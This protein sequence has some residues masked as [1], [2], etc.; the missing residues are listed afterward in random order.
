MSKGNNHQGRQNSISI[1]SKCEKKAVIELQHGLYCG[2]HFISYFENKVFRTIQKFKL[3][4]RNDKICVATSGGKDSL[5][6]LYLV[7]KYL[8]RQNIN[9]ASITALAIDEGIADYRDKT[10]LDLKKFCDD[11]DVELTIANFKDKEHLGAT[12]DI[13][14]PKINKVTGKKPCNVCGVWR[15]YLLNKYAKKLNATKLVT[16]HNLD[17]EAQAIMMNICKANTKLAAKLGPMSGIS[18]QAGFVRRIKPLYL[19]SEK[20]TR[21]YTFL[22]KWKVEYT[23]CP[24]VVQSYRAEIRDSLNSLESKYKGTKH[25]IVKSFLDMM[26]LLRERELAN[27]SKGKTNGSPKK[28]ITCSEPSNLMECNACK[29]KAIFEDQKN[30]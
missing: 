2:T 16:G 5:T 22:K 13:A 18:D 9:S 19:C 30:E 7:K 25:G 20:E 26:P 24:N 3:I 15:R 14:Y 27:I 23:E 12:L 1:C 28:C 4:D 6:V 17:D 29:L 8:E 10:L 21:L 11:H